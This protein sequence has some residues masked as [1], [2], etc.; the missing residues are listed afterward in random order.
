MQRQGSVHQESYVNDIQPIL[1][2]YT[3]AKSNDRFFLNFRGNIFNFGNNM[4]GLEYNI[5]AKQK[6]VPNVNPMCTAFQTWHDVI[7][8]NQVRFERLIRLK[9]KSLIFL[10]KFQYLE[11]DTPTESLL[12][13][14]VFEPVVTKQWLVSFARP[15]CSTG[16]I[17]SRQPW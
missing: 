10:W 16:S 12:C 2:I 15:L 1:L 3:L 11:N 4:T 17:A 7:F 8:Q 14:M 9:S 5:F 13:F 6:L